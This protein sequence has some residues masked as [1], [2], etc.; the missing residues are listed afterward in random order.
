MKKYLILGLC[1]FLNVLTQKSNYALA[2]SSMEVQAKAEDVHLNKALH[3]I[4]QALAGIAQFSDLNLERRSRVRLAGIELFDANGIVLRPHFHSLLIHP[5]SQEI[6][7]GFDYQDRQGPQTRIFRFNQSNGVLLGEVEGS[8]QTRQIYLR[9]AEINQMKAEIHKAMNTDGDGFLP[10]WAH[11]TDPQAG[12]D[13]Q[14][15]L[16]LYAL[17]LTD[18]A[19]LNAMLQDRKLTSQ[20]EVHKVFGGDIPDR[21]TGPMATFLLIKRLTESGIGLPIIGNHDLWAYL[22]VEGVHLPFYDGFKGI[23]EGYMGYAFIG[24][25]LQKVDINKLLQEKLANGNPN[26]RDKKWWARKLSDFMKRAT[27]QQKKAEASNKSVVDAFQAFYKIKREEVEAP[28]KSPLLTD[29]ALVQ[30][31][32]LILGRKF[33]ETDVYTGFRSAAEMSV[34]WWEDRLQEMDD[35]FNQPEYQT[36]DGRALVELLLGEIKKVIQIEKTY[37]E[38]LNDTEDGW[39][40]AVLDATNYL[41]YESVEWWSK[42]WLYHGGRKG[43]EIVSGRAWGPS[44]VFELVKNQLLVSAR[45]KFDESPVTSDLS[46]AYSNKVFHQELGL[47]RTGI[48]RHFGSN[49]AFHGK[50][51]VVKAH[52]DGV[53]DNSMVVKA[54][55]EAE[56]GSVIVVD[57][58]SLT[59]QSLLGDQLAA[60]AVKKNLNFIINGV[61]RDSA[62]INL[63]PVGVFALGTTMVKTEK[64]GRG[65]FDITSEFGG[66]AWQTGQYI[67]VDGYGRI[68]V[69]ENEIEPTVVAEDQRRH[70][71]RADQTANG[72]QS[73][74]SRNAFSGPVVAVEAYKDGTLSVSVIRDAIS[75]AQAGSV[76]VIQ[77]HGLWSDALFNGEVLAQLVE[78]KIQVILNGAIRDQ[79]ILRD[80]NIGVIALD[81][82]IPQNITGQGRRGTGLSFAGVAW[83]VGQYAY[84]D[85]DGIYVVDQKLDYPVK[86]DDVD[87]PWVIGAYQKEIGDAHIW[88]A[89]TAYSHIPSE[90]FAAIQEK[91]LAEYKDEQKKKKPDVDVG[92][93]TFNNIPKT[94]YVDWLDGKYYSY[95][96]EYK[97]ALGKP[98]PGPH[99]LFDFHEFDK[100]PEFYRRN[101]KLFYQ[102]EYGNTYMH[103]LP[104]VENIGTESEPDYVARFTYKGIVYE[105]E[106]FFDGFK[107]IERDIQNLDAPLSELYEALNLVNSWYADATTKLKPLDLAKY[108]SYGVGKILDPIGVTRL[109]VGHNPTDKLAAKKI[110]QNLENRVFFNDDGMS[111]HYQSRGLLMRMNRDGV[112][113][114]GFNAKGDKAIRSATEGYQVFDEKS[115]GGL[116]AP[117]EIAAQDFLTQVLAELEL[118]EQRLI[119]KAFLR[120]NLP[121]EFS[122][123]II[124][125]AA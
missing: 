119:R 115:K 113:H 105:G 32:A 18:M 6:I 25:Q 124:Q 76:L 114:F 12:Y 46:D 57:G 123:T 37:F 16:T 11:T 47:N 107:A 54:I 29:L 64:Q 121:L 55:D 24:G 112:R 95:A 75:Q 96:G 88:G 67:Y 62:E 36:D 45:K 125:Q 84:V 99:N 27:D 22:N 7:L 83:K 101:F 78:K 104:P 80:Q 31:W 69:S 66:Q 39:V 13:R 65:E 117:D 91:A 1:V 3:V 49:K 85:N 120:V 82:E 20:V 108:M 70:L 93:V 90:W 111:S 118:E 59:A 109:F 92:N 4:G 15:A 89:I 10:D 81:H 52:Q 42:D 72:F 77:A 71:D 102:D 58:G 98:L 44:M 38:K 2:P 33:N 41:N 53:L 63:M 9:L 61:I 21:G 100:M 106:T 74:S 40:H 122:Q 103:A 97:D 30:W 35:L 43:K 23:P 34:N 60:K 116:R 48:F 86:I 68:F 17:G 94:W 5:K 110:P 79:N 26:Y 14:L 50:M 51:V 73:F 8:E 19:G 56:P 28:G 87:R